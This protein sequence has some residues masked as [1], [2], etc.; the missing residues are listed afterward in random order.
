MRL[1]PYRRAE[2]PTRFW[3]E[4]TSLFDE[5][6]NSPFCSTASSERW[7]PPVDVLEKDGDLILRVEVPGISEKDID[8]KLEGNV[9]TLKGGEKAGGK[10]GQ[11]RL[12][13]Y[14]ELLRF[15]LSRSFTLPDSADREAIKA[16]FKAGVLTITLPQRPEVKPREIPVS[17]N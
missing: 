17:A 4:T 10:E 14:R 16:D 7:L 6:F 3:P 15:L 13:P 11:R 5:V 12:S 2:I 9:L 1:I 8:L